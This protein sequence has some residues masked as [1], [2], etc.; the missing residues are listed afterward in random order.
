MHRDL[1][2]IPPTAEG[3]KG[4]QHHHETL[5]TNSNAFD[6]VKKYDHFPRTNE[7]NTVNLQTFFEKL[8]RY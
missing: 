6:N 2:F 1:G 5:K 3:L 7:N 8:T 4:F